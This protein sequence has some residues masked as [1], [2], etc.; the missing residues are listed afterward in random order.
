MPPTVDALQE[1]LR[2][3][4]QPDAKLQKEVAPGVYAFGAV[5]PMGRIRAYTSAGLAPFAGRGAQ[6]EFFLLG[7]VH[8]DPAS[9]RVRAVEGFNGPEGERWAKQA[10]ET[11]KGLDK[12]APEAKLSALH[13]LRA[14]P[15]TGVR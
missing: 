11:L 2:K 1:S 8:L 9:G 13:P 14:C 4:E 10:F 5:R 7:H 3:L 15:Q 12:L 6:S